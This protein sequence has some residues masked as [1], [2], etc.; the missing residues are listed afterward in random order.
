VDEH[1]ARQAA[2]V[3]HNA[4]TVRVRAERSKALCSARFVHHDDVTRLERRH[5]DLVEVREKAVPIHR[6]LEQTGGGEAVHPQARDKRAGLPV[7]RYQLW[8]SWWAC[9]SV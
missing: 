3:V 2:T 8:K 6:S 7:A 1:E 4:S 5:E 9:R